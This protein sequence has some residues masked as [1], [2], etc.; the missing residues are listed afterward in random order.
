ML[1]LGRLWRLERIIAGG[2]GSC[3]I[4]GEECAGKGEEEGEEEEREGIG[5]EKGG[6]G[7]ERSECGL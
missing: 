5:E 3:A 2:K 4:E 1:K 7:Q 6:G